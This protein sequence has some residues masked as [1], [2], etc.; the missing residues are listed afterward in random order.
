MNVKLIIKA[1][2]GLASTAWSTLWTFPSMLLSAFLVA[3][4]AEA[5]QFLISQGLALAILAWIQ[6]LPE[7]AVEAVIAWKAGGDSAACFV[8][9]P[10]PGCHVHLAIA[11]F[12]GAIRLL[13][14][15]GWPM[16]YFVAAYFRR[17]G[18]RRFA[19]IHLDA[20]HSV[21]V[22]ATLPPLVYFVWVWYK[23]SLGIADAAVLVAMYG[24][25]LAVLWRFPPQGEESLADAPRVSRWAY[26]KRGWRRIA[27]IGSLFLA[28]GILIYATAEP[29]LDSMLSVA[30]A[31][32]VSEF[33]FVQ[34]VAPFVSEFP[35][36]VSAFHWARRVN[37]APMALMNML[38]SNVNQW[39]VLAAMIPIVYS[40]SSGHP[41]ALPF[42][43]TQ[44]EEIL[45]TVA[46]S[47]VAV[48]L[49][50]R[51]KFE[52]WDA[53]LLFVLWLAQFVEASWRGEVT[54]LYGIWAAVL[55]L[56]WIRARPTAPAIFW[57]LLRGRRREAEALV[58]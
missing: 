28:G 6:T 7:F 57:H 9:S 14:G 44:R 34:W 29:F 2:S 51:M 19:P 36:K 38:S 52:W 1:A 21:E 35:E 48:L 26:G 47:L 32:G 53:L 17:D 41:A 3:W 27:A 24:A 54:L 8:S 31:L 10:P 16:I 15:L 30:T 45:L 56:S 20:E 49:L 4:G 5:A 58:E 37:T 23:G 22:L 18:G 39:T 50:V 33:V 13:V 12:T 42:D 43:G 40:L 46:Q 55:V 25:Y 11:N